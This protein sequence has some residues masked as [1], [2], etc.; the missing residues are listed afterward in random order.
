[1]FEDF[2]QPSW[3]DLLLAEGAR[4]GWTIPR[5][6]RWKC[7]PII[8]HYRAL[9]LRPSNLWRTGYDSWHFNMIWRGWC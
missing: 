9:R 7:L 1:M 8:R 4:N 3:D 5:V 2:P 6:P